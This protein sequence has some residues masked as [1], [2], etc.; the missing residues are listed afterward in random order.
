MTFMAELHNVQPSFSS[1]GL[2]SSPSPSPKMAGLLLR[3]K[4]VLLL[5]AFLHTFFVPFAASET[6]ITTFEDD[7][8]HKSQQYFTAVDGYPD[9]VCTNIESASD[10]S[11][12]SFMVDSLDSGCAGTA[13][14]GYRHSSIL[15]P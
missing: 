6:Q 7:A 15:S 12:S 1:Q 14:L 4:R 2:C 3:P 10:S 9:G 11:Y 5:T 8:C 13:C